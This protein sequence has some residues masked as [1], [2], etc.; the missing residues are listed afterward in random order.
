M[1]GPEDDR[2]DL[3]R[4]LA[5]E[6]VVEDVEAVSRLDVREAELIAARRPDRAGGCADQ[7]EEPDPDAEHK[8]SM[9]VTP[10][11]ETREQDS[12]LLGES[13]A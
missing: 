3:A 1:L 2:A 11:S 5:T 9:V 7:D 8:P 4:A 6:L 13:K 10:R 12:D